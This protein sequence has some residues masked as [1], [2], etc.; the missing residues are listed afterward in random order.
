MPTSKANTEKT[1]EVK[2]FTSYDELLKAAKQAG[3][4]E[5]KLDK[6]I[7]TYSLSEGKHK[8]V[9]IHLV[10]GDAAHIYFKTDKGEKMSIS[11]LVASAA[12]VDDK[13]QIKG[14]QQLRDSSKASYKKWFVSGTRLNPQLSNDQAKT[15]MDLKDKEI[16]VTKKEGFIVPFAGTVENPD[17]CDNEEMLRSRAVVKNFYQI[18]IKK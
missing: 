2:S 4:K 16:V 9:S 18:T 14:V 15:A 17:F 7:E 6:A 3:I 11:N 12:F 1:I 10:E 8:V 13:E 5:A